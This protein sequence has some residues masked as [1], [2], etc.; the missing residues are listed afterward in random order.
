MTAWEAR[1]AEAEPLA[2]GY[3]GGLPHQGVMR[4]TPL[5]LS[6]LLVTVPLVGC[7]QQPA[8]DPPTGAIPFE[9]VDEGDASGIEERRTVVARNA[10]A[11]EELWS[12]HTSQ[13]AADPAIPDINLSETMVIGVFKG[14]SPDGCHGAEITDIT[15]RADGSILVEADLYEVTGVACTE[16]ITTPFHIVKLDRYDA[17]VTFD[18]T[19]TTRPAEDGESPDDGPVPVEPLDQ[20]QQSG[21][22]TRREVVVRNASHWTTLW[23]EHA[24]D[25]NATPPSVDF[26]QRIVL[27]AFRGQSPDTCHG[28]EIINVTR[29][30]GRLTVTVE[31]YRVEA[32]AC[33]QAI[34]YPFHMVT[35]PASEAEVRWEV[36]ET[37]RGAPGDDDG[38]GDAGDPG[39]QG[40]YTC[41][42]RSDASDGP[43]AGS[44]VSFETV[45]QGQQSGLEEVC[46]T[47][48]RNETAWRDLWTAH[49]SRASDPDPR[50]EVDF[51][52]RMIVAI[53]KGQSP[54]GCHGASIENLT[55]DNS[56]LVVH[57]AFVVVEGAAC[58]QAVTYPFHIVETDR[59]ETVRFDVRN[60]TRQA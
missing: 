28:T 39:E 6:V 18:L 42:K 22:E 29:Q 30:D 55:V 59:Y 54:D 7:V 45:D 53:F 37:T 16:Q 19:E 40:S 47:T 34:T 14:T 56:T 32:A 36:E 21:I 31:H 25:D 24:E 44:N 49:Q 58:H 38:E 33:G 57:G 27:A 50:P 23:H 17:D 26:S 12:A 5:V 10:S 9:T 41:R 35:V 51:S 48:A 15:G 13:G 1:S 2:T 46:L 4:S 11:F 8:P 43:A 20:G 52:T 60:E 3:T